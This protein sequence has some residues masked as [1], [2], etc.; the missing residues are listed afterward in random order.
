MSAVRTR[1]ARLRGDAGMVTAELAAC[2]PVLALVLAVA[3]G[4]V[5]IVGARVRAQDG[6]NAAARATARGDASTGQRLFGQT[7]P[8]G[9]RL[10]VSTTGVDVVATVQVT[11]RPLGGWLGSYTVHERAVAMMEPGVSAGGP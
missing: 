4:A 9:A 11:V 3:I 5:S 7:A 10:S 6:A 8:H 1:G 2:L